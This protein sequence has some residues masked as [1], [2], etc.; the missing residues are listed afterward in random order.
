M[1]RIRCYQYF[2]RCHPIMEAVWDLP[3][4]GSWTRHTSNKREI[5]PS[6]HSWSSYRSLGKLALH[7]TRIR[8]HQL[9]CT[10][11]SSLRYSA[12]VLVRRQA[13]SWDFHT[14]HAT[15]LE[16]LLQLST[17][18][19]QQSNKQCSSNRLTIYIFKGLLGLHILSNSQKIWQC[20]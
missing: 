6:R 14:T 10:D 9:F 18:L 5:F 7:R 19:T 1:T 8:Q 2:L 17:T 13:T 4:K 20:M 3:I 11:R 15:G 12:Q 16:Q